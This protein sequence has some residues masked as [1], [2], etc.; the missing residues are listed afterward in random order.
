MGSEF[1]RSSM[2]ESVTSLS[3]SLGA[4]VFSGDRPQSPVPEMFNSNSTTDDPD[5]FVDAN[6]SHGAPSTNESSHRSEEA[7]NITNIVNDLCD[8]MYIMSGVSIKYDRMPKVS[9]YT[10]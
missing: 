3:K 5:E 1:Q 10:R 7:E 2:D 6:E 9:K 4:K 8:K